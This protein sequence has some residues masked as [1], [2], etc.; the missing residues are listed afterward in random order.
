LLFIKKISKVLF[1][2]V[3]SAFISSFETIDEKEK[4]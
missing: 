3:F 1:K 2:N 4:K